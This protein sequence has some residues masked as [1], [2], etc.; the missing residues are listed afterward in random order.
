MIMA[1]CSLQISPNCKGEVEF[2]NL[3][4]YQEALGKSGPEFECEECCKMGGGGPEHD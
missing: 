3:L 4:E 1:E 2:K